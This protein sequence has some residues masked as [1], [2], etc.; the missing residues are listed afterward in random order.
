MFSAG[1][2]EAMPAK[3]VGAFEDLQTR[4]LSD[5]VRRMKANAGEITRSADW[6]I[7]RARELG[8]ADAEIRAAIKD[9]LKI[10]DKEL[11]ELFNAVLDEDWARMKKLYDKTGTPIKF[12]S[13]NEELQ[14]LVSA[15]KEQ[16]RGELENLTQSLGIATSNKGRIETVSLTQYYTETL[17]GA[18]LDITSGAFDY[19][20]VLRRVVRDLTNSG[21]R[22]IDYA[23]GRSMRVDAAARRAVM[24]GVG[25]LTG[26]IS[27]ANAKTLGTDTYEVSVHNGCRPTHL[28][29]QGGWYTM[30]ELRSVCGYGDVAG[31]KGANC[32]H[33]FYPVIPGIDEP[34]YTAEEL[35]RIRE[36]EKTP[37]EYMGKSYTAYEASQRQRDLERTMRARRAEI[38]L[39]KDGGAPEEDIIRSRAAYR[40]ASQEYT[41]F[42]D[43]M[44]L[45]EQRERVTIDG[46]GNIA[47]GKY[48][49]GLTNAAGKRIME[50][51]TVDLQ[52][53][54]NSITQVTS[55]KG[56]VSRNYYDDNGRQYKQIS[57]NDHGH[58]AENSYGEHGEHAHDYVYDSDGK[59][60]GRPVRELDGQERKENKDIL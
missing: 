7:Y 21:I 41:R 26:R 39:L 18:V 34:A 6:Q 5:I 22:S 44:H 36:D 23:S 8:L 46:L 59:L 33:D 31:L 4:I 14:Q 60:I 49:I 47:S 50:V 1:E 32:R 53:A 11:D 9:A 13:G 19:N 30:D 24:T 51:K 29:W 17:D 38:K 37:R 16:T 12:Y 48:K 42:S 57:N 55:A 10:S 45:P 54:P 52:G 43:A 27:E 15:I 20:A 2:L 3:L 28:D 56:G 58:K 40:A 25:Q 35:A